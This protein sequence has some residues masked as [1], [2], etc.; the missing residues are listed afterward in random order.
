M[1]LE[2]RPRILTYV[3]ND[4]GILDVLAQCLDPETYRIQHYRPA[5]WS[6][7]ALTPS[8]R[9]ERVVLLDHFEAQESHPLLERLTNHDAGVPVVVLMER[10]DDLRLT[11]AGLARLHG[12]DR[13][14]L[15]PLR[16]TASLTAAIAQAFRKLDHWKARLDQPCF[17]ADGNFIHDAT[18]VS[19]TWVSSDET[20]LLPDRGVFGEDPRPQLV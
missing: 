18:D 20:S 12:A 9:C 5:D 8:W 3:G 14:V 15:K 7:D 17:L 4:R 2:M 13:L 16:D 6:L 1:P 19:Q 11:A 10:T